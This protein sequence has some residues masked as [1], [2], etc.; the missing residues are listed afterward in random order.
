MWKIVRNTI[1]TAAVVALTAL[2]LQWHSRV[3]HSQSF[4]AAGT[5]VLAGQTF[6]STSPDFPLTVSFN[7]DRVRLGQSET[8]TITTLPGASLDVVTQ[9]A[10]SSTNNPSTFQGKADGDGT[11]VFNV[12]IDDFHNLGLVRVSVV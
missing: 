9:Y 1:F 2:G 12:T 5:T 10:D 7:S 8:V 11:R 4:V 3:A 6:N